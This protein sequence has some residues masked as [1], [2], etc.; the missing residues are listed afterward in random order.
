MEISLQVKLRVFFLYLWEY[1]DILKFMRGLLLSYIEGSVK[2]FIAGINFFHP[3]LVNRYTQSFKR[4]EV[5]EIN[6]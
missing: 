5:M 2:S 3:F 4:Y 6:K 1:N